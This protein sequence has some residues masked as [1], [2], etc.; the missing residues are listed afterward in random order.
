MDNGRLES[1][2]NPKLREGS[3]R[4][5]GRMI[6]SLD[7]EFAKRIVD[8]VPGLGNSAKFMAT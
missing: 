4:P 8:S 2:A 7:V 1:R 5:V 6:K 3:R